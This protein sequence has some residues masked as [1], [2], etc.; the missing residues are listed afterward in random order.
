MFFGVLYISQNQ[1]AWSIRFLSICILW[2][3]SCSEAIHTIHTIMQATLDSLFYNQFSW[4][5]L[6]RYLCILLK[7]KRKLFILQ[8]GYLPQGFFHPLS[9]K[10]WILLI[11]FLNMT[12][13]YLMRNNLA[14]HFML[15]VL[16]G[17]LKFEPSTQEV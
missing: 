2:K 5:K 14:C 15:F 13:R 9:S 11:E 1:L 12:H 3:N 6:C 16:I 8:T 17:M 7:F 4:I 10:M